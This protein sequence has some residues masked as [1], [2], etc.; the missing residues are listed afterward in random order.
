MF[1]LLQIY[2][3]EANAEDGS[4]DNCCLDVIAVDA[5]KPRLEQYLAE[6]EGRYRA[7]VAEFE[8]WDDMSKDWSDEHDHMC[9]ALQDRYSIYGSL[10]AGTQFKILETQTSSR[11]IPAQ[12]A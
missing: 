2:P 5:S 4:D 1:C 11:P 12:A 6:Y 3:L 8:L 10:V 7:A 9:A